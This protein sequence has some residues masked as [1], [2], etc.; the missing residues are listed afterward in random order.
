MAQAHA[1]GTSAD[2]REPGL[3]AVGAPGDD[4]NGVLVDGVEGRVY[5]LSCFGF[6]TSW[7]KVGDPVSVVQD[8]T[9]VYVRVKCTEG[10]RKGVT[11]MFEPQVSSEIVMPS[12]GGGRGGGGGGAAQPAAT[13][14]TPATAGG[15]C[16]MGP[17]ASA[18]MGVQGMQGPFNSYYPGAYGALADGLEGRVYALGLGFN[19][20]LKV[21]DPVSV[22]KATP[23]YVSVK[24]IEGDRKGVTGEF[25]PGSLGPMASAYTGVQG[26]Q[27]P[28]DFLAAHGG[29]TGT[30]N[31]QGGFY[32]YTPGH[33]PG[34]S[35]DLRGKL[36]GATSPG[37]IR[38]ALYEY[39][40]MF[41]A[42]M[43]T[44][45]V[46]A[47]MVIHYCK[48]K[49]TPEVL[50]VLGSNPSPPAGAI[51]LVRALT[52]A[53]PSLAETVPPA[54]ADTP[55]AM[56][57]LPAFHKAI[58]DIDVDAI[59]TTTYKKLQATAKTRDSVLD[60]T[61]YKYLLVLVRVMVHHM[62]MK[63][64]NEWFGGVWGKGMVRVGVEA[65][66][67]PVQGGGGG[68]MADK[69]GKEGQGQDEADN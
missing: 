27:G 35:T 63:N 14:Y 23:V 19:T 5:A 48:D 53:L 65:C 42:E 16:G 18:F 45:K 54:D 29:L 2:T 49:L 57:T 69:E 36:S 43:T 13:T 34:D 4:G 55:L 44:Y 61:P 62:H 20:W 66:L 50:E 46:G 22:V 8:A 64:P 7:L 40:E 37:A 59:D 11:G 12:G 9:P 60:E 26:M 39:L 15:A 58:K 17:M 28:F 6:N 10:D 56:L 68:G 32:G 38:E 51:D 24:C 33:T 25:A 31:T 30:N 21:G 41:V 47:E 3:T 67:A 1:E 52:D